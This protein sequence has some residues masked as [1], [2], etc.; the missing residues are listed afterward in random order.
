VN[1]LLIFCIIVGFFVIVQGT[2]AR[3]RELV[4]RGLEILPSLLP[5]PSGDPLAI[6]I[7]PP[8][9]DVTYTTRFS[10]PTIIAFYQASLKLQPNIAAR[11]KRPLHRSGLISPL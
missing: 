10:D 8:C 6:E 1:T 2:A 4:H 5:H 7:D 9:G 11:V 3:V